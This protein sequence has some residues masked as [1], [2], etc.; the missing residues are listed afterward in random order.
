[1]I[2]FLNAKIPDNKNIEISL[3]YVYGI[4]RK[5]ALKVCKKLGLN[6]KA[7]FRDLNN[8]AQNTLA[9]Y[10]EFNYIYG[11]HLKRVKKQNIKMLIKMRSYRG[12]RHYYG[13]LVRGQRS[14]NKKIRR[15]L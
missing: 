8:Q 10:I 1:M 11:F 15:N 7:S 2:H 13:Y 9:N 3:S 6:S 5:E 4:G 12:D 14:K